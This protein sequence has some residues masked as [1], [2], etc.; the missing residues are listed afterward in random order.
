M[1][2]GWSNAKY[3]ALIAKAKKTADKSLR[4]EILQDAMKIEYDDGAYIVSSFYNKI[5]A[6]S[7]EIDG[8]GGGHPSGNS[9]NNFT[10]RSVGF[11]A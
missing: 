2:T 4:N 11:V 3:D 6:Y 9:L 8:F 10:F 7:A 1:E 5:D